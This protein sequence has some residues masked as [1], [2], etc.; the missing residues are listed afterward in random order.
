MA[1]REGDDDEQE[2][3]NAEFDSLVAGLNLD[4]SSPTTYLD[5][6][7]AIEKSEAFQA[8]HIPSKR[9]SR[10]SFIES[11]KSAHKSF[12]KWKRNRGDHDGDGAVL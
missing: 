6:L 12:E 4:Q 11:L 5:E 7:D 10:K 2:L 9:V 8:P 3:I 1:R